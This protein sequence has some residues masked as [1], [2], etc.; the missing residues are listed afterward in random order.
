M[1]VAPVF[2]SHADQSSR[3][4]GEFLPDATS[5]DSIANGPR[6]DRRQRR[7]IAR[8][9][10]PLFLHIAISDRRRYIRGTHR[11]TGFD[12]HLTRPL[13]VN[14]LLPCLSHDLLATISLTQGQP[15]C[16]FLR[17]QILPYSKLRL[18]MRLH[19]H[20]P[21]S[22]HHRRIPHYG[23]HNDGSSFLRSRHNVQTPRQSSFTQSISA[24]TD[25]RTIT[26]TTTTT[27]SKI[28]RQLSRRRATRATINREHDIL[29][30][31]L[32]DTSFPASRYKIYVIMPISPSRSTTQAGIRWTS[33]AILLF[34]D[35]SGQ[36]HHWKA[37]HFQIDIQINGHTR[38]T[39]WTH[40]LQKQ[41]WRSSKDTL[42]RHLLS[43]L[44]TVG[45]TCLIPPLR[46]RCQVK[47]RRRHRTPL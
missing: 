45:A 8:I 29:R 4:L 9:Q 38:F 31:D 15:S 16:R 12:G 21:V 6:H 42:L 20:N 32:S 25:H 22:A 43:L 39:N 40:E 19:R 5:A 7:S 24:T 41:H 36:M 13:L 47:L 37:R 30:P 26:N 1:P 33:L 17:R 14:D 18:A 23:P 10:Q 34:I 27:T 35:D 28:S 3:A 46:T 2:H 44:P 11:Q